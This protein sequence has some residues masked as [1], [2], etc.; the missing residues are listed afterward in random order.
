M[1]K[2]RYTSYYRHARTLSWFERPRIVAT[3]AGVVASVVAHAVA[4]GFYL[5]GVS[6]HNSFLSQRLSET[7]VVLRDGVVKWKL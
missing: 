7:I 3:A 4:R 2:Y 6:R 5:A 1:R